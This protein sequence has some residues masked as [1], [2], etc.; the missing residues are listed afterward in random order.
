VVSEVAK[1]SVIA[2]EPELVSVTE[3]E[4]VIKLKDYAIFIKK[5]KKHVAVSIWS[6]ENGKLV[7]QRYELS[8][9]W[10]VSRIEDE[11]IRNVVEFYL[12]N[13]D[14]F[15]EKQKAEI[16]LKARVKVLPSKISDKE[17]LSYD[18]AKMLIEKFSAVGVFYETPRGKS[19]AG[20]FCY[21]NGVYRTCEDWLKSRYTEF[22]EQ[23]QQYRVSKGVV[24]DVVKNRIVALNSITVSIESAKPIVAFENGLFDWEQFIL[25]GDIE[26]SVKPF[27]K[28]V[29][30]LHKIPHKLD[31]EIAKK[32][33]VGL[34]KYIPP[35]SCEEL[36]AIL[37]T[38]SPKAFGL[39][40]S[41]AW[42]EGVQ[43]D[44]LK[45]R[46]CFLLEM[47]GRAM[48]PGYRLFG[49]VVFKDIFVLLGPT[50]S[51][52]TT[53][54]VSFLGDTVLGARN[55]A[56]SKLSSF[57]TDDDEDIRRLFGGL[58]NVL[59]VFLPDVSKNERVRNWSYLRSVSGGD[60][61][62]A[63][64]LKE[65]F[66]W[67]YPAYK[68]Y[69]ASNDP[70]PIFESGEAKEALLNRFKV[71]EFKHVF[72]PG[73]LQFS[74]YLSEEDVEAV[75]VCSLYAVR[76]AYHRKGYS[77]TGVR[78]V[79]DVWLR[80]SEPVYRVVMEMVE[81]GILA[82][83]P[84]LEISSDDFYNTVI[85]YV[86]NEARSKLGE[87]VDEEDVAEEVGKA[88]P[89]DQA[90]FTKK[91]KEL[92]KRYGVKVVNRSGKRVFKGIGVARRERLL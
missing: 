57:T 59:A 3:K 76:L 10:D 30:V 62:E 55:Y 67:Y 21:D 53:F 92:L 69:I 61:V 11:E 17:V 60:P 2:I 43:E 87:D 19:L 25:S 5:S 71:M 63:R 90:S 39:L 83:S 46:V 12:S 37:S 22:L 70:P 35:R 64:R 7:S 15:V 24:D 45:S 33:R 41:W 80:Y 51:G 8:S 78:D 79:E 84:T 48:L 47:I 82:L 65:N 68:I 89:R 38:L 18:L 14:Y 20:V 91:M 77:Y 54:L 27:D 44:L 40:K 13:W 4:I 52:K 16:V 34:E 66:F 1:P 31:V 75:V 58:F 86:K 81:R 74:T 56:V 85:D 28:S 72:A 26:K 29:F 23:I 88:M 42:Y 50:N 9:P 6:Y 32:C 73:S 49:D 36:L